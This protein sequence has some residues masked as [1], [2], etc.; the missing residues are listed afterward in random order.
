LQCTLSWKRLH[1]GGVPVETGDGFLLC[2]REGKEG[3]DR[4][5]GTRVL[6]PGS[7]N[8]LDGAASWMKTDPEVRVLV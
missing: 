6:Q 5:N 8:S 7:C 3:E 2:R 1:V 4:G